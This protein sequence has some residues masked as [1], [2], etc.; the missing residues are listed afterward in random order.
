[1]IALLRQPIHVE[2]INVE[3]VNLYIAKHPLNCI[4]R[5][6]INKSLFDSR[7]VFL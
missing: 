6:D 7:L 2:G 5:M 4:L 3:T 1:M